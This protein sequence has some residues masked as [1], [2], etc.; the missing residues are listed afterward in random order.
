VFIL[1]GVN[2]K[3]YRF[4]LLNDLLFTVYRLTQIFKQHFLFSRENLSKLK[5]LGQ[6]MYELEVEDNGA[7]DPGPY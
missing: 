7:F 2:L 3:E 1:N 4:V 5:A 6:N